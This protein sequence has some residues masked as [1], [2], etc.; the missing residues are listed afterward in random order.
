ME[1]GVEALASLPLPPFLLSIF[2]ADREGPV[3]GRRAPPSCH[4]KAPIPLL[5]VS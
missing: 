2:S 1:G 4:L 5:Q 3:Q